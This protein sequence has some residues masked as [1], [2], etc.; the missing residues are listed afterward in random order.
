[1]TNGII[2]IMVE[3]N[4]IV[5]LRFKVIVLLDSDLQSVPEVVINL[6]DVGLDDRGNLLTIKNIVKAQDYSIDIAKYY[7]HVV[8]QNGFAQNKSCMTPIL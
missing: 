5:K 8:L 1:M 4:D 6:A 7:Q 3:V 2:A